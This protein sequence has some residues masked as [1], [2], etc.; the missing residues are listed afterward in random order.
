MCERKVAIMENISPIS[1][2]TKN[3][4]P[5]EQL[6]DANQFPDLASLTTLISHTAAPHELTTVRAP[7]TGQILGTVPICT[8]EDVQAALS[9]AR[10]A[11]PAWA[12]TR[13]SERKAI[14]LR[15]HDL[16]L[17]Y[18]PELLNLLQVETGKNRLSAQDEVFDAIINCRYYAMRAERYL[19]PT[20]RKGALP[21]LTHTMELHQPVG[22]VGII[23]PWNYPLALTIS[24]TIPALLAGNCVVLKPAEETPFIALYAASLLYQAGLPSEVFQIV[25]GKGRLVGPELIK[26]V[27]YLGFTGGTSTGR[28]LA[29]QAGERLI[30]CS[31]ELGGK[32]AAIVLNDADLEK[33]VPGVLRGSFSNTGQLCV[34]MERIYVQNKIYDRF[35]PELVRQ[36]QAMKVSAALDFSADMGSLISQSQLNK[37]TGHVADALQKG[38]ILLTGGKARPDLGPFFFE[39][40]LLM[41]V[42]PEMDLYA[43][44]TFGPVVSIYRFEAVEQA[45]QL[46]NASVYGLNSS[47]W[48]KDVRHGQQIAAQLQTGMSNVN[49]AVNAAWGSVD[50]PMGGMK[51]SGLGRRH[52]AEGIL[53][54]TESRT[55]ATQSLMLIGPSRFLPPERYAKV[56]TIILKLMKSLPG[57]R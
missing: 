16:I 6:W 28:L 18:Q 3:G 27:D 31:L 35:V 5:A 46:V 39:P 40:T 48:T 49:E 26:V 38:A 57:L 33:A 53:K 30:K 51:A 17:Q 20:R 29:A 8:I 7:F 21:L 10:T 14:F 41:N 22:V 24:D 43:E 55:L 45:I 9:T 34:H 1:S 2:V 15:F 13:L 25:T 54:Y 47:V 56:M 11:Q 36:V 19:R 44:E 12:Q 52:G 4:S 50:S 32:N 42:T 23:S 37:V